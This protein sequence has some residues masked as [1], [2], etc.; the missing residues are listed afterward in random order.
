[1]WVKLKT[2]KQAKRMTNPVF[3]NCILTLLGAFCFQIN[4]YYVFRITLNLERTQITQH[5]VNL[6][7][8]YLLCVEMWSYVEVLTSSP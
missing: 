4:Y 1:M 8:L 2:N 3:K 6:I 5:F 7:L